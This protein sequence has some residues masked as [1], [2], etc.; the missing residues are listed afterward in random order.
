MTRT[1]TKLTHTSRVIINKT[2]C[3]PDRKCQKHNSKWKNL[4]PPWPCSWIT[5]GSPQRALVNPK[6]VQEWYHMIRG[7]RAGPARTFSPHRAS[8]HVLRM[9]CD[10]MK[11]VLS[12]PVVNFVF[13]TRRT[14]AIV[15]LLC[16]FFKYCHFVHTVS[17]K[18]QLWITKWI[19]LP[20]CKFAV[21]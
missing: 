15:I 16:F 20:L 19:F 14:L 13:V 21:S 7:I 10:V 5:V 11:R 8:Y 18:V 1:P 9:S 17:L 12:C 2:V 4:S 3:L 6:S